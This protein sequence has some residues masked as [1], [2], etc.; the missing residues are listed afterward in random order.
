MSEER[1]VYAGET[2]KV[3]QKSNGL[4]WY[5]GNKA[6][7][8]DHFIPVFLGGS[9]ALDNKVPA[10]KWCN[11][12]KRGLDVEIWRTKLSAKNGLTF[13]DKQ[14]GFW[15]SEGVSLPKDKVLVFFFEKEGLTR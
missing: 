13:S 5:C 11:K 8:I 10:C 15:K 7:Q 12:S 14:R 2:E 3:F 1:A 6:E 9:N 4:C